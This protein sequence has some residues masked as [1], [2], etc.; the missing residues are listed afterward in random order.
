MLID[1]FAAYKEKKA[2]GISTIADDIEYIPLETTKDCL[3]DGTLRNVIVTTTDIFVFDYRKGYRFNRK[4][5]FIN[6]IGSQGKGPGEYIRPMFMEVDTINRF[7]YFIDDKK[8]LKYDYEGKHIETFSLGFGS[9]RFIIA[10]TGYFA[11]N[12]RSYQFANSNERF[13]VR[14]FSEKDKKVV[15]NFPSEHK[16]KVSGFMMCDPVAYKYNNNVFIKDY[17]SD[18][19]YIMNGL[20][21]AKPYAVID[22]GIFHNRRLDDTRITT[23]K[24]NSEERTIFEFLAL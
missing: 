24:P 14:F 1:A 21:N 12:D 15:S 18:T 5:K 9:Q 19:I 6:S 8:M 3:L 2:R 13:S 23:G 11:I 17:W 4:G 22:K 7:V 10:N 16:E 20:L